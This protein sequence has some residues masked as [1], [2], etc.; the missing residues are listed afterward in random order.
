MKDHDALFTRQRHA[1]MIPK[2]RFLVL[3]LPSRRRYRRPW[4]GSKA[5]P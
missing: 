1:F 5:P 4:A 3:P 2:L